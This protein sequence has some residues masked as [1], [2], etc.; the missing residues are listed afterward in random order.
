MFKSPD[1][2][3]ALEFYIKDSVI[4][5]DYEKVS[6]AVEMLG[7]DFVV[8]D[9]IPYEP[10]QA[11]ISEYMG[12]E[13]YGYEWMD[14]RDEVIN[15]YNALAEMN[16]KTYTAVAEGPLAFANYGGNVVPQF[17]G[18]EN[19]RKYYST[20]YEE[21][22]EVLHRKGKL[23]GSHFDAD[24]V[25][26]MEDIAETPL[27]YIEAYDPGISPPVDQAM[28]MWPDKILWINWPSSWQLHSVKDVYDDTVKLIRQAGDK[29]R[30]LIGITEDLPED[31]WQG[32]YK[33]IM[34]AIEHEKKK[35]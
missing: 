15:L 26:I 8:R 31:R 29:G 33:A 20:V 6:K 2:Y 21:A 28:N 14:N 13:T 30:F 22:A 10:L 17:I 3:K 11:I 23:I 1:D 34:D 5:L 18:R 27:D 19:F 16:R 9:Q 7:D 4:V 32:N 24:N 25:T 12:P 35:D